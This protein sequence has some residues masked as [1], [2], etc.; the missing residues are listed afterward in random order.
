M[1]RPASKTV[2]RA[3]YVAAERGRMALLHVLTDITNGVAPAAAVECITDGEPQ[4]LTLYRP[5][6]ASGGL[7]L[8]TTQTTTHRWI[9]VQPLDELAAH[10]HEARRQSDRM[11]GRDGALAALL[12]ARDRAFEDRRATW[13]GSAS[14]TTTVGPRHTAGTPADDQ[15]TREKTDR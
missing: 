1:P 12:R 3:E 4:T 6:S 7:V 14:R 2:P 9:A 11:A 10:H 8:I 5:T 13:A 15:P